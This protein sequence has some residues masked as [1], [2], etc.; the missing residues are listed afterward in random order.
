MVNLTTSRRFFDAPG[1]I[2]VVSTYPPTRCGLATFSSNLVSALAEQRPARRVGV[3]AIDDNRAPRDKVVGNLTGGTEAEI[4]AATTAINQFDTV[5][6]QHEYGIF[7]GP[8]GA[9]AVDLLTR[10]QTPTIAVLHT[11][12]DRPSAS[13]RRVLEQVVDASSAAVVMAQIARSRLIERYVVDAS[14][15]HVIP[16]GAWPPTEPAPARRDDRPV[17]LTWGLLGPGKGIEHAI[18]ALS[19]LRDLRPAPRYVIAG[20]THPKVR[21]QY[22]EA[23]REMLLAR[24]RDLG[25]DTM[26]EFQDRYFGRASLLQLIQGADVVVLPYESYEQVTSGVL[27]DALACGRPVVSTAFPHALEVCERGAGIAVR[28]NSAPALADALRRVLTDDQFAKRIT[29]GAEHIGGELAWN[30]VA[31]QYAG[32]ADRVTRRVHLE[33]R[34]ARIR[35]AW[36]PAVP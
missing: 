34:R 28:H 7:D 5:I 17:L 1:S 18:D 36:S 19:H 21:E 30:V 15:V 4:T 31:A 26:I 9:S 27:V 11:V 32:L 22:G 10:T 24:A 16:H 23:Y 25:V 20:Q 8:D 35:P 6:V 3:V 13:Q 2:A 29:K 12:L 14:R 33:S